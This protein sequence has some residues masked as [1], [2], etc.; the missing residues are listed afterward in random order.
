M[1]VE[2]VDMAQDHIITNNKS[3]T[4]TV[5]VKHKLWTVEKPHTNVPR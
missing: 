2:D 1:P 4:T 3:E 5:G